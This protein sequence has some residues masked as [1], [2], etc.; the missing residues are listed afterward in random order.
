MR[1]MFIK[2][3][4]DTEQL[5]DEF[6]HINNCRPAI[7]PTS[8]YKHFFKIVR[9]N[10]RLDYQIILVT[11]GVYEV[12]VDNEV[13]ELNVGDC[14]IYPPGA[15]QEYKMITD[16]RFEQTVGYFV[17]F[18][19]T[20]ADEIYLKCGFSGTTILR[21][22]SPEVKHS[23]DKL[24]YAHNSRDEL[25]EISYLIRIISLLAKSDDSAEGE[26]IRKIKAE[27]E[28]IS[29]HF[30]EKIDFEAMAKRCYISRSRFT[31]LFTKTFGEPPTL[32]Q[33]NRKLNNARELLVYSELS[34]GE[35]SAQCGFSDQMYF[36]KIF[37][38][39]YNV[40]PLKY[41]KLNQ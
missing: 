10:G 24:F 11:E 32:Y 15:V 9:P 21:S 20:A 33:L 40:S 26:T 38:K 35:I 16:G 17:H 22:V 34:V 8:K 23:F 1:T 19:G 12:T 7:A 41:R 2:Q 31:H 28:Y 30:S 27:A 4:A 6:L 5:S 13:T 29:R 3:R 18:S 39:T 36:S 25:A 37:K 14:V